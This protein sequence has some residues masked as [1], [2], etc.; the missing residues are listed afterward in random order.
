MVTIYTGWMLQLKYGII[1][2]LN[3]VLYILLKVIWTIQ[4]VQQ[5][6]NEKDPNFKTYK[7]FVLNCIK[8]PDFPS[9]GI[10]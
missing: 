1:H 3:T 6:H 8:L 9:A 4:G 2:D 5:S 7:S 10:S